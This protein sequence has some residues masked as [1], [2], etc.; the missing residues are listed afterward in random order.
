MEGSICANLKKWLF[1]FLTPKASEL[2]LTQVF[3]QFRCFCAECQ[4]RN[5]LNQCSIESDV[6]TLD[7][8]NLGIISFESIVFSA[9][10]FLNQWSCDYLRPVFDG[11]DWG[12]KAARLNVINYIDWHMV[13]VPWIRAACSIGCAASLT[14]APWPVVLHHASPSPWCAA[15]EPRPALTPDPLMRGGVRSVKIISVLA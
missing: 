15:P 14:P 5:Y 11:S 3:W 6:K 8:Q 10:L 13:R 7:A 1:L 12:W 9:L 4:T 2:E